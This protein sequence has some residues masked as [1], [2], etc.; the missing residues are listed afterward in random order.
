ME[1]KTEKE[2]GK[3]IYF[4]I[5][6]PLNIS[7]GQRFR[8]EHYLEFLEENGF[9]YTISSFYTPKGWKVLF[10]PDKMA[11]K[12]FLVLKGFGTRLKDMFCI[13]KYD[14]VFV[15]R[16][17]TPVGPPVF[18]YM[19]RFFFKKKIIYDFD[20]AIWVPASSEYNKIAFFVKWFSKIGSICKWSYRI[21]PGN[22]YLGAFASAYN[23]NIV[24]LPTVVDTQNV[25]NKIQDQSTTHPVIGW[26]G[27]F[28]TLKYLNIVLPVLQ[29]MQQTIDFTFVVIAVK[30]PQLPLKNYKFIPW[31]RNTETE[32]LLSIHIGVMPL[33]DDEFSK[34]K[35]GFKAIQYMSLGIPAVV[36]PVGVNTKIV[37]DGINGFVCKDESEWEKRLT[38]LLQNKS[39]RERLGVQAQKKIDLSYSVKS[40]LQTFLSVFS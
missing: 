22:E 15:F 18:E 24:I 26:T 4:V 11:K 23:K 21:T 17:M 39:L 25:H 30:D 40:T 37:D 33:Y 20:D 1:L 28:S 12:I 13:R 19:V 34:G 29:K 16:E 6:A 8:F 38:E 7:P 32:D 31:Q 9:E 3:K 14:F 5:P 2:Q 10:V 27:T 36:S 35:C